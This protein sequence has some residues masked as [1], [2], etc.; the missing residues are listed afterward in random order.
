M[1]RAN[2]TIED[3]RMKRKLITLL[4]GMAIATAGVVVFL[5]SKEIS[6]DANSS[7]V[8]QGVSYLDNA[9]RDRDTLQWCALGLALLLSG[10]GITTAALYAWCRAEPPTQKRNHDAV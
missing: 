6:T 9:A 7:P 3:A 2:V 5:F 4:F 1:I 10:A 8:S